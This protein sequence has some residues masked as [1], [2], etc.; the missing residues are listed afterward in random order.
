MMGSPSKILDY[1]CAP[2]LPQSV[3]R[4]APAENA[5]ILLKDINMLCHQLNASD[6]ATLDLQALNSI[7]YS[8]KA[9]IAS[10]SRSQALLEKDVF[11]PNQNTWA[12]TAEHMGASR[13]QAKWKPGPTTGNTNA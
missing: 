13:K 8:L 7:K 12:E 1:A 5:D 9:A 2:D 11:H 10:A 3:P 4:S 6:P